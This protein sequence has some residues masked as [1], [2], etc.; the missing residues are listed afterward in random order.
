MKDA[1]EINR[2][3]PSYM[4]STMKNAAGGLVVVWCQVG[5]VQMR[6]AIHTRDVTCLRHFTDM[7]ASVHLRATATQCSILRA[8]YDLAFEM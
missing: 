5:I 4:T 8:S 2:S 3:A 1:T 6:L 7:S